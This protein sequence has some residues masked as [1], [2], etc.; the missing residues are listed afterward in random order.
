MSKAKS[1]HHH[2]PKNAAQPAKKPVKEH[3]ARK[4][5]SPKATAAIAAVV[6]IV[7][8]AI[9]LRL[10]L[11]SG[12]TGVSSSGNLILYGIC[13]GVLLTALAFAKLY[14]RRPRKR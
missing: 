3:A 8:F 13:F 9:I 14:R 6:V 11:G 4:P 2:T 7:L 5:L 12:S 1:N 10:A